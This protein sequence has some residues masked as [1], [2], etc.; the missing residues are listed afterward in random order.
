MCVYKHFC[1][2]SRTVASSH[3]LSPA[4]QFLH[5]WYVYID[6][7]QF[8]NYKKL[9]NERLGCNLSLYYR[10]YQGSN[11]WGHR[12]LEPLTCWAGPHFCVW[13]SSPPAHIQA[14]QPHMCLSACNLIPTSL[15]HF[16]ICSLYSQLIMVVAIIYVRIE[17]L[18]CHYYYHHI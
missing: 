4:I 18:K 11:G 16:D 6:T 7:L 2:I 13:T 15:P 3:C 1:A 10:L 9:L 17:N 14:P 8:K 5:I 12:G